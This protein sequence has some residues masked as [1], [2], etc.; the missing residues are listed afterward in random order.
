MTASV[1][2]VEALGGGWD[3]AKLPSARA[4]TRN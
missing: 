3:V 1:G 2:L 4:V